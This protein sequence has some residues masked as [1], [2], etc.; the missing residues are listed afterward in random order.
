MPAI[1]LKIQTKD[2]SDHTQILELYL[3][4]HNITLDILFVCSII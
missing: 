4:G 2:A 3:E 1:F